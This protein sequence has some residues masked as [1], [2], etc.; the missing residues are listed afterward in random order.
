MTILYPT[1]IDNNISLPIT[2]DNKM[3]VEAIVV[4]T[5]R[6]AVIAIEHTLGINPQGMNGT[7][8]DRLD[9][10]QDAI[11]SGGAAYGGDLGGVNGNQVVVGL[12]HIPVAA[13]MP[14]SG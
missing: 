8:S 1:Q 9:V 5:L 13:G 2:I 3:P 6:D 7:V 4:N 14:I 12:Q 11:I 10:L